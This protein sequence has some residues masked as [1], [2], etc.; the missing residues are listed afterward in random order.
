MIVIIAFNSLS[1]C[2]KQPEGV[3]TNKKRFLEPLNMFN[4]ELSEIPSEILDELKSH[5]LSD[6]TDVNE[7]EEDATN[8]IE[9]RHSTSARRLSSPCSCDYEYEFLDLGPTV[10]PRYHQQKVC[11]KNSKNHHCTFGSKCKELEHKVLVLMEMPEDSNVNESFNFD[12]KKY[13]WTLKD[14]KVDCRCTHM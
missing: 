14:I 6:K 3:K 10:Y 8:L 9:K 5:N 12:K 7:N 11:S 4:L 1:E 2:Y 13:N